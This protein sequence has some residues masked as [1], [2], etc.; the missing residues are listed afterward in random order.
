MSKQTAEREERARKDKA[1]AGRPKKSQKA[2][3]DSDD[4][5]VG[6]GFEKFATGNQD[7]AKGGNAN[8]I[9]DFDFSK[10]KNK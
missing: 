6:L 5:D 9:D 1:G 2:A 4:F 8:D 10:M 7:A 3:D